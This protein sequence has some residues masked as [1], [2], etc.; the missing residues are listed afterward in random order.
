MLRFA[1]KPDEIFQAMLDGAIS[2][3]LDVVLC[4]AD[5]PEEQQEAFDCHLPRSATVFTWQQAKQQLVEL[6]TASLSQELYQLTD[7]HWLLLY[8]CLRSYCDAYTDIPWCDPHEKYGIEEVDF[9]DIVETFFGT[10]T[11]FSRI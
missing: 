3:T 5:D 6:R 7:Y 10:Q 11:F 8:E 2:E 4:F 9:A 1:N